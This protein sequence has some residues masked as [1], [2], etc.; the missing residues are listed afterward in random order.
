MNTMINHY[1]RIDFGLKRTISSSR[2]CGDAIQRES[3]TIRSMSE[4]ERETAEEIRRESRILLANISH[5]R[6]SH[7]SKPEITWSQAE[8]PT[9]KHD[10]SSG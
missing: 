3:L 8:P 5:R 4:F 1:E 2:S 6:K 9:R 7:A 10:L